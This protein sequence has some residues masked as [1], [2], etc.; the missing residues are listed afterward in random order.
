VIW[1]FGGF[2]LD[3]ERFE[4]RRGEEVVELRR[5]VFDVLRYLVTQNGR[6]VS[7][8]EL[9][10][11]VWPRET[12]HEGV[13]A[14]NIAIL[15]R[16]LGDS[17]DDAKL[18]QTVHGR[19]YRFTADVS[20]TRVER[21]RSVPPAALPVATEGDDFVGREHV[22]HELHKLLR[23][24]LAGKGA[25]AVISGEAGIGKTRTASELAALATALGARV[26]EGR[27]HEADGAP[28]FW[29]WVQLLR[30]AAREHDAVRGEP[31]ER[32]FV[33]ARD[34]EVDQLIDALR[35][36]ELAA[37]RG[38]DG[39]EPRVALAASPESRFRL[40]DAITQQ[41]ARLAR[42]QPLVLIFDDLHWAD[43]ATLHLLRFVARE[44][45]T[46]PLFVLGTSR[47]IGEMQYAAAGPVRT[48]PNGTAPALRGGASCSA[49][50]CSLLGAADVHRI[51]LEGLSHAATCAL[52]QATLQ[53]D[54]G[55]LTLR[56]LHALTEGNPF[57][58]HEVLRLLA[59]DPSEQ[60]DERWR[61]ELPRRLREV[62]GLRLSRL[63]QPAQRLLALA[64]VIGRE[65]S[66]AVLEQVAGMPRGELLALLDD[67]ASARLIRET[68]VSAGSGLGPAEPAPSGRYAFA[69]ALIRESLYAG[70][71]E[72]ERVRVHEQVGHALEALFGVDVDA[73]LDELAH[74]FHRAAS[75]GDVQ[76][77]VMYCSRA[78]AQAM[79][80]LAFEQAVLNYRRALD[81]LGCRLPIDELQRFE[82]KLALGSALFRAGE[83][84]NP[85]LLGAAEIARRLER[86]ELLARVVLAMA[87]WPRLRA[88]GRTNNHAL[89]PLLAESIALTQGD[90]SSLR[91]RLLAAL[92]LNCPD[93]TPISVQ[94]THAR[95]ALEL[96]RALGVGQRE[97]EALYDAL[98]ARLYLMQS[99][100]DTARRLA[101]AGELLEVAQRI[102]QK[103]RMF[104]AHELRVQPLIALGD[105]ST[106][107]REIA[108]CAELADVLRLPRC[109]LQVLRFQMERALGDGRF[110]DIR[111]LTD[112]AVR[113]RGRAEV[114]PGYLASFFIWSNY[115]RTFRG[116]R[117][118]FDRNIRRMTEGAHISALMRV[119]LAYVYASFGCLEEARNWYQPLI[120]ADV[121]DQTRSDNRPFLFVLLAEAVSACGDR[122][123]AALLYPRLLPY[124]ALNAAHIEWWV[125]FGS[126]AHW[127]GLLA[128][129]LGEPRLAA[130]HFETALEF[131][132]SLGARPALAR[133][134]LAYART[135]LHSGNALPRSVA[136]HARTLLRDATSMAEQLEMR[137]LLRDAQQ[138]AD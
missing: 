103:E 5:K 136:A 85:A 39:A 124:A 35:S 137:P 123:A 70:L 64:S 132:A 118:W 127:L 119:H 72:P 115:E 63:P 113:L 20:T 92:A 22:M 95:E 66:L 116:K 110:D 112:E 56:D 91:V 15:R 45:R 19:G 27:C 41:L 53:R 21:G 12:I 11:S 42:A 71:S 131:N 8:D 50:L 58:V 120:D 31:G 61:A 32:R 49:L 7:K 43:E 108:A 23:T 76:R 59:D 138:L 65:F 78:A 55:E 57:F 52:A 114:S 26:L 36:G 88:R 84:G 3:E 117:T 83:D 99:P 105:L 13:V 54:L 111:P 96:A 33:V 48:E 87:G 109:R 107:D 47:D 67:A 100:E 79:S 134:S 98:L 104:T 94:L 93:E 37:P 68:A 130:S 28:A 4:L 122:A 51:Y 24:A 101:L 17:R 6:L 46:L 89:Y 125:Y 75:A 2:E 73:H 44:L 126:C 77:A 74:H 30:A 1:S 40:F 102:G 80:L 16:A 25:F 86:P 38:G 97:D 106:A 135:L 129:L 82:L 128:A 10:Q 62:I 14:Q 133:T 81:A 18:I 69:H 9:L 34:S 121:L 90:T 60:R 29:P